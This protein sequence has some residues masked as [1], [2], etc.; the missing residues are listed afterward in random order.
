MAAKEFVGNLKEA[1]PDLSRELED[2]GPEMDTVVP[3]YVSVSGMLPSQGLERIKFRD[4]FSR[5]L[6]GKTR[7]I[8]V[9]T[10]G[11]VKKARLRAWF[12]LYDRA[13]RGSRWV[14]RSPCS[15]TTSRTT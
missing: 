5:D 2:L 15:R 4:F 3:R 12:A 7:W 11:L 13:A 8:A 9:R 6:R 14:P 1:Y 10:K